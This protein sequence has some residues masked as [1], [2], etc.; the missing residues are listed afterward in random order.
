MPNE[1]MI[2]VFGSSRPK[3]GSSAY[4]L[5]YQLGR[6][7]A[8]RGWTLCNGGYGGTMEASA[9]GAKDAG[10]QV[11][12]VTCNIWSRSGINTFLDREICT[13]NLYDRVRTLVDTSTAYI[14]L[15]GGTGTLLEVSLVWELVNKK[16]LKGRPIVLLGDCW[17][18]VIDCVSQ[19]DP[20]CINCVR[21]ATDPA[22]AVEKIASYQ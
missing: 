9:K 7:I 6:E 22:D 14:A 15:P 11:I 5:A 18:G 16:F 13:D 17:R 21:Q 3:A 10:G 8:L 20:K 12:G 19:D 1:M 2:A 4:E